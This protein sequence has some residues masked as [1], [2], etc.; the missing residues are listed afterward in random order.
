[1]RRH[2]ILPVCLHIAA[3]QL[4]QPSADNRFLRWT[5]VEKQ[6]LI[7]SNTRLFLHMRYRARTWCSTNPIIRE[8][9]VKWP[10]LPFTVLTVININL[11]SHPSLFSYLTY[12]AT[13]KS[14]LPYALCPFGLYYTPKILLRQKIHIF[15]FGCSDGSKLSWFS[16][17]STIPPA[18]ASKF[19][20]R[21]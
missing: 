16:L 1:M 7:S 5:E 3:V 15:L 9:F 21:S 8:I 14:S 11:H 2:C 19:A 18:T 20:K 17:F 6:L 12:K 4:N 10:F 13:P